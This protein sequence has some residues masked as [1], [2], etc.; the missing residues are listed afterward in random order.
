MEFD[1][2]QFDFYIGQELKHFQWLYV[3]TRYHM[4]QYILLVWTLYRRENHDGRQ[5][6]REYI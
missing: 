4:I 1:I 6:S 2:F 3:T 5:L